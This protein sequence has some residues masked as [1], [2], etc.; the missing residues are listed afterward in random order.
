MDMS[1]GETQKICNQKNVECVL[2]MTAKGLDELCEWY[3]CGRGEH[4]DYAL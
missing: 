3:V 2:R 4:G 1:W